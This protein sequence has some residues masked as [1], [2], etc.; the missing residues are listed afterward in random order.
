MRD[1]VW[2]FIAVFCHCSGLLALVRWWSQHTEKRLIILNYH[3]VAHGNL[4]SHLLHLRRHYHIVPLESALEDLYAAG[5]RKTH[6]KDRRSQLAI[7]FDD[8]Y[9]DN[10]THAFKLARELHIPITIFL[11][12][13]YIGCGN[14]FWWA[15][16]LLL[17]THTKIVT[18]AGNTYAL[19]HLEERKALALALN[20]HAN[21]LATC[22]ERRAFL[23]SL[24]DILGLPASAELKEE[25]VPLLN[26]HQVAEMEE[27][28][29]VT[30][31]AHTVHHPILSSL[32]DPVDVEHEVA[33][34]RTALEQHLKLPVRTFAYPYGGIK[35]IGP[36]GAAAAQKAGYAWAVTTLSGFNTPYSNPHFLQR[37]SARADH[38]WLLI[39]IR[40]AGVTDFCLR[41]LQRPLAFIR[42]HIAYPAVE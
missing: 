24:K 25:P 41:L 26:W 21:K 35:Q 10:Y 31:G 27:S 38:H 4:R 11:V 28:G 17:Y 19:Q 14:S 9:A 7:T 32:N 3:Q 12:S 22:T 6:K 33:D 39:A 18:F 37:R 15:D 40:V 16:R 30:F 5:P 34:C 36:Y 20:A 13:G 2:M 1:R 8:G 23:Y 42:K 29:W